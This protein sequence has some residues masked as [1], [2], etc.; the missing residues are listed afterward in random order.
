ML[1]KFNEN[2]FSCIVSFCSW[3]IL[4]QYSL[5]D[6]DSHIRVNELWLY[7]VFV[8]GNMYRTAVC[9]MYDMTKSTIILRSSHKFLCRI[10]FYV[11]WR[12]KACG[13]K[14]FNYCSPY[15]GLFVFET[16]IYEYKSIAVEFQVHDHAIRFAM[17]VAIFAHWFQIFSLI[18]SRKNVRIEQFLCCILGQIT[19]FESLE[20]IRSHLQLPF[21][22]STHH[23][24]NVLT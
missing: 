3:S 18:L 15:F 2:D 13:M 21:V 20:R 6:F 8:W 12:E 19:E 22:S 23:L 11:F 17:F 4:F 5:S 10:D 16:T 7:D 1:L 24:F 14:F 9:A